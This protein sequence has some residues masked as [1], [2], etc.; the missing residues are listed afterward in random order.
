[1]LARATRLDGNEK[2]WSKGPSIKCGGILSI[3]LPPPPPPPSALSLPSRTSLLDARFDSYRTVSCAW[4]AASIVGEVGPEAC[5]RGKKATA[6]FDVFATPFLQISQRTY[7]EST[8]VS[9]QAT[10]DRRRRINPGAAATA[11]ATAA[12][13]LGFGGGSG[14]GGT[15]GG[16]GE[17]C[18]QCGASYGDVGSLVAHVEAFHSEVQMIH[19]PLLPQTY[20]QFCCRASTLGCFYVF[21]GKAFVQPDTVELVYPAVTP[22]LHSTVDVVPTDMRLLLLHMWHLTSIQVSSASLQ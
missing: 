3:L 5:P 16:Q 12:Q 7:I 15:G 1:M 21:W 22:L 6:S 19:T 13:T 11:T 8:G 17:Q 2:I 9:C 20:V 18:P 14:G 10:A 4:I